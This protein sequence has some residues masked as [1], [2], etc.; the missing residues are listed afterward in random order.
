MDNQLK[1]V[2]GA[3][4]AAIGTILSAISTIPATSKKMDTL[5]DGLDI[6]GNT[7]QGTGNALQADAQSGPSIAK[8]GNEIQAIGNSTVI[9]GL[10]LDLGYEYEDRLV[11]TGNWLQA[12]GGA[13]A[14]GVE[15]E[16]PTAPGQVFN[17]NG[18]LLQSI[19]N[20]LQSIGG[21]ENLREKE[22]GGPG[23]SFNN[24][25]AIGSWIQAVGSVLSLIGVIQGENKTSNTESSEENQEPG[26]KP[27]VW[28][29]EELFKEG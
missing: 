23:D 22:R 14:L 12:L 11:I 6:A 18:N 17:I 25:I 9:A 1:A 19:G 21:T 2:F 27:S 29:N 5:F 15:L 26:S 10:T 28:L 20:S 3:T 7:L 13:S 24:I 16:N 4:L 8:T